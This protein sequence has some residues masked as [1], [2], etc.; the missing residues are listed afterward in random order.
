MA[1][2][3]ASGSLSF[4]VHIIPAEETAAEDLLRYAETTTLSDG[5][6]E[7]KHLAPGKY[8]LLAREIPEKGMIE[9]Q[10][11]AVAWDQVER[12]R[13]RR[14][15]QALG[16]QIELRP[17]QQINDYALRVSVKPK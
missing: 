16:Q 7:L 13:L 6:F 2:E 8:F 5:S 15:A 9:G 14:E 3:V 1:K 12:A 4:R 10:S 17:C 11:R